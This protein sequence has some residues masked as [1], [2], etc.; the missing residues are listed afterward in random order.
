MKREK[1]RNGFETVP[2]LRAARVRTGRLLVALDFDGTLAEIVPR[3]ADAA[4]I[5]GAADALRTLA[6]RADTVLAVITGRGV[7]DVR[8]R[9]GMN[10][11]H[12]AGNHGLEIEGPGMRWVHPGAQAERGTLDTVLARLEN[13]F[14]E[15]PEVIIEDKLVSL[16]VHFRTVMDTH[17]NDRIVE[18]VYAAARTDGGRIRLTDGRKVVEIRPDVE[19]D[20]GHAFTKLRDELGMTK[21]PAVYVGDDR[22]DEDAF[23]E[24]NGACDVGIIVGHERL[25]ETHAT[26]VLDSPADV[27]RFLAALST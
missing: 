5:E 9:V 18:A 15:W 24:L 2:A 7:A 27:V 6:R 26:A 19:W 16:S 25:A 14:A 23:R 1:V 8:R 13:K 21:V 20:K 17:D 11:I 3:P 4:L 22:T 12:Y 10:D